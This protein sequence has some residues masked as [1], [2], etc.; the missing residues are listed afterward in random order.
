VNSELRQL[1]SAR[2]RADGLLGK[3]VG[4]AV[5]AGCEG[6]DGLERYL[7]AGQ[8][9]SAASSASAP[10][11]AEAYLASLTVEGFRGIGPSQVLKLNP[12]P[13]LTLVVGRNGS[14]KSSFAEALEVLFT[15]DSKRWAERAK[16]WKD[17]WRNLHHP[18]PT[19]VSTELLLAGTGP[20]EVMAVWDTDA[21]FDGASTTVQPKGRRKTSL[22]E[23]GWTQ[24][25]LWFRP[26]LS[27]N[28]LG[29][30]L[31]EGPSKLYDALSLM[32]GLDDLVQAQTALADARKDRRKGL[33]EAESQRKELV[34]N[35]QALLA[36]AEDER[37]AASL[38][39][40]TSSDWGLDAVEV[41]LSGAAAGSDES[42]LAALQQGAALRVPEQEDVR[43]RVEELRAADGALKKFAGTDAERARASARLL[44]SALVF[45]EGHAGADCPICGTAGVLDSE[46]TAATK[47][48]VAELKRRATELDQAHRRFEAG[49]TAV[50]ELMQ[51]S[52]DNLMTQIARLG[53]DGVEAARKAWTAWTEGARITDATE[54]AAHADKHH[55]G[56][57]K[58]V[59]QLAENC[60]R[61]LQRR[62]D[63]WRP[64]AGKLASWLPSAREALDGAGVLPIIKDAEDW[65]KEAGADIRNERFAPIADRATA[66]WQLLRQNSN[67]ELGQVQLTGTGP[68]R[69]VSLDVTVDG[70]AGAALGVMSQG[71]LHSLA[72]SLF[73]P[74]ATL[75]E[76][77]FRF[78]VID[79]PVQSMDPARVDGLARVLE[80]VARTRQVIVFTHDDRLSEAVRRLRISATQLGVTR[81]PESVVEVR[82]LLDPVKGN[83]EDALAL[84]QT[85]ELPRDV[86]QRVVPGFCRAALE[87]A[88]MELFRRRRLGAGEAHE[89]VEREL[90]SAGTLTTLA[91]LALFDDRDKGGDVMRR[92][93]QF[94]SWAGD[95]F[96][97]SNKGA[98]GTGVDDL[99][100]LVRST[101]SL[102]EKIRELK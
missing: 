46:W 32:L 37:A 45:H 59:S 51:L 57:A 62:Q 64:L 53:V 22:N 12:G 50:T 20:A 97:Q 99:R 41:L 13:G 40:L 42:A 83:V 56:L 8:V 29:S 33:K 77:P 72:L 15:G 47:K 19:S 55:P 30:M 68:A 73:L 87:A 36:E 61:E 25:L 1:V 17:G 93:N 101:E 89:E 9:S 7:S 102:C 52:R 79:D 67:V 85:A 35:L 71:E 94:G 95:V 100:K 63:R 18:H 39:A 21:D 23:L 65:L 92:L 81:R 96:V 10:K 14:G 69:R 4:D 78:V 60:S 38:K 16:V 91:A 44:E 43:A 54:L 66:V 34:D 5:L 90:T 70:V 80:D 28:E 86:M 48:E 6:K 76:S 3:T 27:Y 26:F 58:V 49:R 82:T 98:H 88:F 2:L 74:R 84:V 11:A 24:A 75:T 31:D